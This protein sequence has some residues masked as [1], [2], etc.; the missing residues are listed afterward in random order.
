M[1]LQVLDSSDTNTTQD[2]GHDPGANEKL[3]MFM[4]SPNWILREAD[5]LDAERCSVGLGV[6]KMPETNLGK[7]CIFSKFDFLLPKPPRL[8]ELKWEKI[9]LLSP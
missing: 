8:I 6:T 1:R 5:N 2:A 7:K 9:L 4:S 3:I